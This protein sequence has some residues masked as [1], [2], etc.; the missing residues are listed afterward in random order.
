M[1]MLQRDY[2]FYLSLENSNCDSY[3]TEKFFENALLW[4]YCSL[5]IVQLVTLFYR[6]LWA[7]IE[8]APFTYVMLQAIY[9]YRPTLWLCTK[10]SPNYFKQFY[11]ACN[12][13]MQVWADQLL[14]YSIICLHTY[15]CKY[16]AFCH[17][18]IVC[19]VTSIGYCNEQ[20]QNV[21]VWRFNAD[22]ANMQNFIWTFFWHHANDAMLGDSNR[23]R[24]WFFF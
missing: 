16:D 4:V 15:A 17:L 10:W 3:I 23:I 20:K 5:L 2:K 8:R 13:F 18:S 24:R 19:N 14:L 21:S 9:T 1:K 12:I 11:S 7:V 6:I 22:M